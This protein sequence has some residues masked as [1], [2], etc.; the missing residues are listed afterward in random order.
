MRSVDAGENNPGSA[1]D[2]ETEASIELEHLRRVY[3]C[4]TTVPIKQTS[5]SFVLEKP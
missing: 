4:N 2:N 1:K 3:S 5:F